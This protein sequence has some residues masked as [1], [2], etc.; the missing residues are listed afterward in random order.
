MD[1]TEKW[2]TSVD[3]A[4]DLA[5]EDLNCSREDVEI[6]VLEEPSRGFFGIG[7]KLALVR[8]SKKA[9]PKKP[10]EIEQE[11]AR[12]IIAAE[13]QTDEFKLKAES[14]AVKAEKPERRERAQGSRPQ[15]RKRERSRS[16]N[17]KNNDRKGRKER[18]EK[19]VR[20][21]YEKLASEVAPIMPVVNEAELQEL[22]EHV[23]IT[24]VENLVKEM[25]L[26]IQVSG[27]TDG[28][29]IFLFLDGK[30]TGSVIGKFG[31]TLDAI[32]YLAS[33]V[34][35]K[36]GG[37]Y[38]R[39]VIDAENY[40]AK[41]EKSLE[42]LALRLADKVVRSRRSYKLEPMNPY[43]RKVIHATLQKDPRVTTRSEGQDPYRRIIIELN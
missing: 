3:A 19:G 34:A 32:Q 25:G 23:S 29:D 21:D 40:R 13:E 27:K 42:K 18:G 33:L 39:V 37:D 9:A 2:G 7:S 36:E 6:E 43:E 20:R 5:L 10:E 35:N 17:R 16:G 11:I 24:F 38:V 14:E 30:D 41:R 15:E 4:V 8:V 12:E 26:D 1:V 28:K 22:T 31:S